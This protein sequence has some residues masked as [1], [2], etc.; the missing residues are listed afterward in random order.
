MTTSTNTSPNH[1]LPGDTRQSA[2]LSPQFSVP[3]RLLLIWRTS[4]GSDPYW[5]VAHPITLHPLPPP[6]MS[7]KVVFFSNNSWQANAPRSNVSGISEQRLSFPTGPSPPLPSRWSD[8][9]NIPTLKQGSPPPN[10]SVF[11]FVSPFD[12]LAHRAHHR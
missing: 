4:A 11:D 8:H 1:N 7:L 5:P 6:I 10:K 9:R 3:G 2:L 12:A